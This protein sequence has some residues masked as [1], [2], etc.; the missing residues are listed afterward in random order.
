MKITTEIKNKEDSLTELMSRLLQKPLDPIN[1]SIG[2]LKSKSRDI[3]DLLDGIKEG[4][5]ASSNVAYESE[6]NLKRA[7]NSIIKEALPDQ[8]DNIKNH[9][10][11]GVEKLNKNTS[12]TLEEHTNKH[13]EHLDSLRSLLN[14][15]LIQNTGRQIDI[16]QAIETQ[17]ELTQQ[18][19][20]ST[21]NEIS[22][23]HE[24]TIQSSKKLADQFAEST[25]SISLSLQETRT[26][27]NNTLT[28]NQN[29]SEIGQNNLAE[30]IEKIESEQVELKNIIKNIVIHQNES[31][32]VLARVNEISTDVQAR[33][34]ALHQTD[35][36]FASAAERHQ[37]ALTEQL[38]NQNKV[39]L[40]Q[41]AI[42]EAKLKRLG[43][44]VSV[45]FSSMLGYV[46]FDLW[47]K[48]H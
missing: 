30:I 38:S 15:E 21:L 40:T 14:H 13:K 17:N 3:I 4:F 43:I 11:E 39:L 37:I 34:Q 44:T 1:E 32:L 5:E 41:I 9:L 31:A 22:S 33:L 36:A 25:K 48:L 45:F 2:D 23:N 18:A 19:V 26:S 24:L 42:G 27:L 28:E 12:S 29:R 6:K 16:I 10:N 8:L 35:Q 7:I 46:S 47:S 20:Q